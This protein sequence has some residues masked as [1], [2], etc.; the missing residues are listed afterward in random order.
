MPAYEYRYYTDVDG[1]YHANNPQH[2][3]VKE[4]LILIEGSKNFKRETIVKYSP[5]V[6]DRV[7]S[8]LQTHNMEPV[9][10]TSWNENNTVRLLSEAIGLMPEGRIIPANLRTEQNVP[11]KEWTEWKAQAIIADQALSPAPFIWVDDNAPTYWG[12]Y[13]SE[14]VNVP[15]LIITPNSEHGLTLQELN[16]IE[17]FLQET[18]IHT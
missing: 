16:A 7:E 18:S 4:V 6:V 11:R 3:A 12:E 14:N 2:E 9:F 17:N 10:L 8:F 1:V 13:V 15:H 5:T